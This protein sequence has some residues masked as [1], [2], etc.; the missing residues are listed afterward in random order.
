MCIE[1]T[2]DFKGLLDTNDTFCTKQEVI[3]NNHNKQHEI[4]A[5]RNNMTVKMYVVPDIFVHSHSM[6]MHTKRKC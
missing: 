6:H 4:Q 5:Y 3:Q 2:P 1:V